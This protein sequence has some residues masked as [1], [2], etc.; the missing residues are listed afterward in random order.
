MITWIGKAHEDSLLA[1]EL[2]AI[3]GCLEGGNSFIF[4]G[5]ATDRLPVFQ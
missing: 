1:E 2:L 5:V 3:N 4:S